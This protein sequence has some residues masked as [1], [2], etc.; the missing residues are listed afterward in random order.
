VR[1]RLE[2][3]E[4]WWSVTL[5]S[6]PGRA[7]GQTL[8]GGQAR[9]WDSGTEADHSG[10]TDRLGELGEGGGFCGR[11]RDGAAEARKDQ[12]EKH[13]LS[14]RRAADSR[15]QTADSRQTTDTAHSTQHTASKT[16]R[17]HKTLA[18][19]EMLKR[20]SWCYTRCKRFDWREGQEAAASLE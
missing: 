9:R 16:L 4:G 1:E 7:L 6:F 10:R 2:V 17:G 14:A 19:A 13:A 5:G 20:E 18:V 11:G 15:Q 8:F 12:R 3:R